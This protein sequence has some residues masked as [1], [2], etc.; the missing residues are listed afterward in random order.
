[1]F[2]LGDLVGIRL[3]YGYASTNDTN[4]D[5]LYVLTQLSEASIEI[6]AESTEIK[7]ARGAIVK[8]TYNAKTADFTA[9]NAFVNGNIMA[10]TSGKDA[11]YAT[12]SDPIEMPRII[13]VKGSETTVNV[14]GL[15]E[16]TL[17]V[18][19]LTGDGALG[20]KFELS[21]TA[22]ATH[23]AYASEVVTLPVGANV[24]RY[25]I[26]YTRKA[27]DGVKISNSSKSFPKSVNMLFKAVYSD[28]C[29]PNAV[30]SLYIEAP[31]FQVAPDTTI[32]INTEATMDLKAKL[33][34][35]YCGG[36][37]VL[38]NLYFIDDEEEDDV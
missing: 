11:M 10:T 6:A 9:T 27:T 15:V 35:D 26:R 12:A 17:K 4:M 13:T 32:S 24:S 36:E 8:T 22:D 18:N 23:F 1:M 20:T 38:Y 21:T 2:R 29:D 19:E 5:P 25:I 3:Q 14:P 34:M 7:D 33:Q 30:K 37:A 16:G 31:N 28:P